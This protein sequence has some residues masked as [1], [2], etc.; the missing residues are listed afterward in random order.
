[1]ADFLD[2]PMDP[3]AQ[4]T[5]TVAFDDETMEVF[6]RNADETCVCVVDPDRET[7]DDEAAAI[8]RRIALCINF[9][10]GLSNDELQPIGERAHG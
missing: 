2:S 7:P 10:R 1:M 9:C 5:G 8:G 4:V 6:R 3:D